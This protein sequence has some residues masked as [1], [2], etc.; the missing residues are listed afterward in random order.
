[1]FKHTGGR[2]QSGRIEQTQYE[3]LLSKTPPIPA[4][5]AALPVQDKP[6][7]RH[8]RLEENRRLSTL[9]PER[10]DE[11]LSRKEVSREMTMSTKTHSFVLLELNGFLDETLQRRSRSL[12]QSTV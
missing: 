10:D 2:R 4:M 6:K 5:E 11:L 8:R 7:L 3:R 1:M 12:I 9:V